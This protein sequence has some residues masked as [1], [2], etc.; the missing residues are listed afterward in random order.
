VYFKWDWS[1]TLFKAIPGMFDGAS[2]EGRI[3]R[4]IKRILRSVHPRDS[5][6]DA[7]FDK[8]QE[9]INS[10]IEIAIAMRLEQARFVSTF[11]IEGAAF[12]PNR[13]T[14]GGDEQ[15]GS[16]RMCTFPGIIK[17]AMFLGASTPTDISI[18]KARVHLESAFQSLPL[19]QSKEPGDM[20]EM[21]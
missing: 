20:S 5:P 8:L 1:K 16:I 3:T 10:A 13:H 11:P 17:Q 7:I 4:R 14:T 2:V 18:F 15:T 12:L 19:S 21:A 6:D 9:Y